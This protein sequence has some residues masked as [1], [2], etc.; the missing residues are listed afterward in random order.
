MAEAG[1]VVAA[2]EELLRNEGSTGLIAAD[3]RIAAL[4][5]ALAVAGIGFLDPGEET[6]QETRLTLVAGVSCEGA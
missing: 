4:A 5:E 2:C 1:E 3:A 6:T